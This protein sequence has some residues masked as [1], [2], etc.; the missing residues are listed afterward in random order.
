MQSCPTP[1]V[2]ISQGSFLFLLLTQRVSSRQHTHL[3]SKGVSLDR[4][5]YTTLM[6]VLNQVPDYRKRTG[7]QHRWMI[8]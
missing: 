5:Q 7:R 3:R 4:T 1:I 2:L 8:C 6:E